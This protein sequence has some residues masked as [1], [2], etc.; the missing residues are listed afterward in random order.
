MEDHRIAVYP[1]SYLSIYPKNLLATQ[2]FERRATPDNLNGQHQLRGKEEKVAL[3]RPSPQDGAISLI[4]GVSMHHRKK[5]A[6][7]RPKETWRRTVENEMRASG[8]SW[9]VLRRK[10]KDSGHCLIC[11]RVRRGLNENVGAINFNKKT[12]R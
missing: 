11:P 9:G 7:G 1:A 2:D 4:L 12:N 3:I 5:R 10:A 6:R 8:V